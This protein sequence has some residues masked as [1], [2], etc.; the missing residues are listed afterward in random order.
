M[1]APPS[2]Q[3]PP[4]AVP[5]RFAD[6]VRAA[7]PI[8]LGYL[9]IGAAFGVLAATAGLP[10]WAVAAMSLFVYAGSAQFI[11]TGLWAQAAPLGV[12][13]ATTFL[14]NLRHLL[15]SAALAP[16]LSD[17]PRWQSAGLAYSLTDESFA[18]ASAALRGRR[19]TAAYLAGL[20]WTAQAAWLLATVA[21]ALLGRWLPDSRRLGLDF[22]LPAMFVALLLMQVRGR[23][24]VAVA[25]TAGGLSV[26]LA[27]L[28]PG[29]WNVMAATVAAAT[30][31]VMLGE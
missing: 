31:G 18:V 5:G 29:H 14:V 15:L 7:L 12:I 28:V 6:G 1:S 10:V 16:S 4:A 21:G 17:I 11:G 23:Q 13:W 30:L 24:E 19:T 20:Q 8:V 26:A 25:L 9:P 2:P 22:A 27:V 3:A